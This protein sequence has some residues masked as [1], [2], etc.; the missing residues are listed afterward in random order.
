MTGTAASGTNIYRER[1]YI[2]GPILNI[3]Y[4]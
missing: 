3:S 4:W 1:F 2:E